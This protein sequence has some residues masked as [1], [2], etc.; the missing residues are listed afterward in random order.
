MHIHKVKDNVHYNT[1][2]SY[3]IFECAGETL[4]STSSHHD[5]LTR[6][7]E[8]IPINRT[9]AVAWIQRHFPHDDMQRAYDRLMNVIMTRGKAEDWM[10]RIY[11]LELGTNTIS[12]RPDPLLAMDDIDLFIQM[13]GAKQFGETATYGRCATHTRHYFATDCH[14]DMMLAKISAKTI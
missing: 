3:K 8:I 11:W 1:S 4:W 9:D 10:T 13:M 2:K 7:G 5:F 14:R 6:G 12:G